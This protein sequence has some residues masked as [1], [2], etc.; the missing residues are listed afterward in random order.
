MQRSEYRQPW[1]NVTAPL[2][3]DQVPSNLSS[4]LP[5]AAV[6]PYLVVAHHIT[7]TVSTGSAF[8]AAGR[9]RRRRESLGPPRGDRSWHTLLLLR[10]PWP[11]LI[12]WPHQVMRE[13][14]MSSSRERSTQLKLGDSIFKRTKEEWI[15]IGN[16]SLWQRKSH[17]L[18]EREKVHK[19]TTWAIVKGRG[20]F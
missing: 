10:D 12:P 8:H 19:R 14:G 15:L 6:L 5:P 18:E 1:T 3:G 13:A 4:A 7:P 11:E 16:S 20:A 2:C 9:Q 17:L